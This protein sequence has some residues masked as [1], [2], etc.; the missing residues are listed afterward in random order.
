MSMVQASIIQYLDGYEN[1]R[2]I[3]EVVVEDNNSEGYVYVLSNPI[4][5]AYGENVYKIGY[6]KDPDERVHDFDTAYPEPSTMVY[7]FKHENA[8]LLEQ[9]VHEVLAKFRLFSNREFF[10]CKLPA[11][12]EMIMYLGSLEEIKEQVKIQ[13]NKRRIPIKI[14]PKA[15]QPQPQLQSETQPQPQSE[16][17]PQ[18]QPE[19]KPIPLPIQFVQFYVQEYQYPGELEDDSWK[20]KNMNLGMKTCTKFSHMINN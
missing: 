11:I 6:S 4:Y 20:K 10:K 16:T 12:I 15:R 17:Q 18:P 13:P 5:V 8:R 14:K 19:P 2:K 3:E 1:K 9:Q 7:T